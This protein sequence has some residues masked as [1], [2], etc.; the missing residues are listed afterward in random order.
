MGHYAE[1]MYYFD[2]DKNMATLWPNPVTFHVCL[3]GSCGKK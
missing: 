2:A 1:H 3:E